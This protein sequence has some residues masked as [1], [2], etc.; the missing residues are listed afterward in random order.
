VPVGEELAA[1]RDHAG[2]GC[3]LVEELGH[4]HGLRDDTTGEVVRDRLGD[5]VGGRAGVDHD[6]LRRFYE[7]GGERAHSPPGL[8]LLVV[9]EDRTSRG[10][11]RQAGATV[12]HPD[13]AGV[14]ERVQV[15]PDR[16]L[17]DAELPGEVSDR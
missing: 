8:G 15:A 10:T 7:P 5:C 4:R 17:G 3:P 9:W 2:G 12:E 1:E 11:R 16:H 13:L 14:L 6:R